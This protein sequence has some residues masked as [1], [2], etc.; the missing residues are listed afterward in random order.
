MYA[1]EDLIPLSALQHYLFCPR[2]CALIHLEQIWDENRLTA[3]G[4]VLHERVD[5]G[6]AE[7]RRDVKR[8]FGLPIR[9]LRLGLS[10]KA[11]VVEFHHQGDGT[12]LPYPVEHK[13]GRRKSEDW[14]RVQ[15][16]GQALC[17]EEMLSVSIPEGA[18]FYGSEQRREVVQIADAL[19]RETEEVAAAVHR[20][21]ASERTPPPEYAKKCKSCSLVAT[22][23]PKE[24][25]RS[26]RSRVQRYLAR[27]T[28]ETEG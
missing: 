26:A 21:L 28:E 7:K 3:E 20:M 1:E 27:V 8:V 25:G 23:R 19:R 4:R 6:G 13:W 5:A 15:L 22:C 16:C 18:L 2:Q 14:D 17:L 12:W 9:S 10:G 24:L 11:D